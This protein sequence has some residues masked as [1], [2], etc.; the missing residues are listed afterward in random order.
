MG[1]RVREGI[2]LQR[3]GRPDLCLL[4]PPR[5]ARAPTFNREV[6]QMVNIKW[7]KI[8][9]GVECDNERMVWRPY[10]APQILSLETSAFHDA[11]I[12]VPKPIGTP[13][14]RAQP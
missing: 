10:G 9:R 4:R 14:L 6:N 7:E 13:C 1:A 12:S 3:R 11:P 8:R 5:E 2:Q